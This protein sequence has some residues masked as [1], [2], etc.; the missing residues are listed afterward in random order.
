M[1]PGPY[2]VTLKGDKRPDKFVHKGPL[3][4]EV[5]DYLRKHYPEDAT[6]WVCKS[7]WEKSKVPL[8]AIAY[9]HRPGG[10]DE[11]KVASMVQRLKDGWKPDRV[12]LVDRG[13]EGKMLVV[14][15]YHRLEALARSGEKEVD[16]YVGTPRP[17]AG[18]YQAD[19]KE[20]QFEASNMSGNEGDH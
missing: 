17:G 19:I 2:G 12:V 1:A 9:A 7:A 8:D 3:E 16:A 6:A 4:H 14:D 10:R 11:D 15:G 5:H 13:T 20:M 18:D